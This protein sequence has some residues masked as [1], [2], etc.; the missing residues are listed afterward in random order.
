M[1]ACCSLFCWTAGSGSARPSACGTRTWGSPSGAVT[2]TPRPNDN[3]A[4]AK[5]GISPDDPGQRRADAAVC[6]LPHPR[7]RR[8]GLATTSSSTSGPSPTGDPLD[9]RRRLRPGP[10]ATAP[11]RDRLRAPSVPPHLRDLAA[12]QGRR[13]GEREGA[14]SVTPRSPPRSTRTVTSPSRTPARRWRPPA[15]SPDGRSGCD[16]RRAVRP[17]A[18]RRLLE[19][20]MAA[21]RP[22]FRAR[23]TSPLPDDPVFVAGPVRGR[24]LRPA[25]RR[26]SAGSATRHAIRWRQRG[27]PPMEEFLAD[28]GPTGPGPQRL[29]PPCIV[30]GCRYG[31]GGGNGLCSKHRDRWDRAGEPDLADLGRAGPGPCADPAAAECRLPFC[32][33]MGREPGEDLLHRAT[34]TGGSDIGRPDLDRFVADCELVGTAHIDLHDLTPQLRLEIQ[35]ALQCRHDARARTA[36]APPGHARCPARQDDGRRPRCWT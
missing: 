13:D 25:R 7:V 2:V 23:S 19:K 26:P 12:A 17:A 11:H 36:A 30:D 34:T 28:P 4:R 9:L 32:D 27:R 3:R 31:R 1:I 29:W 10:A 35:Y 16:R 33:A 15:G 6:R 21:V 18:G 8:A 24:R 5:A 20:L 22:E 14:A